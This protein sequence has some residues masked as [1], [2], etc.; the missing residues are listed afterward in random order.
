M[1]KNEMLNS[2]FLLSLMQI[3]PDSGKINDVFERLIQKI[4]LHFPKITCEVQLFNHRKKTFKTY[5][6]MNQALITK[7]ESLIKTQLLNKTEI[8]P[9]YS[10]PI[11]DKFYFPLKKDNQHIGNLVTHGMSDPEEFNQEVLFATHFFIRAIISHEKHLAIDSLVELNDELEIIVTEKTNSL[12]KEREANFHASKMAT[13]GQIASGVAHEINN[14]LTIIQAKVLT[15]EKKLER[16][17]KLDLETVEDLKKITNTVDRIA[18]IV[19]G[20]KFVSRDGQKDPESK[21][22]LS[23]LFQTTLEFCGE[24]LKNNQVNYEINLHGFDYEVEVKETQIVQVLLNLINNAFDAIKDSEFKWIRLDCVENKGKL[25]VHI[26]DSGLGIPEKNIPQL[27]APFF[28]TK[29]AG[30]GTG[31]GLSISKTIIENHMGKLFYNKESKNTD[32]VVEIPFVRKLKLDVNLNH[33]I[34]AS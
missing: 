29:P 3:N 26:I 23:S 6:I 32:F 12:L 24:R 16:K 11:L 34:K 8:L 31:L 17:N 2:P 10:T 22:N 13:L 28:T 18:K 15:M 33:D 1:K 9:Y 30:Q 7:T 27:M 4:Q 21:V 5:F 20:L 25:E 14:P 19:K